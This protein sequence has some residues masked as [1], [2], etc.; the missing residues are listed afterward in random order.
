METMIVCAI[1][2]I[3]C[4][5]LCIMQVID[6]RRYKHEENLDD[7]F[8]SGYEWGRIAERENVVHVNAV[9]IEE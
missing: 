8:A 7:A 9:L 5:Y 4:I 3:V 6:L 2:G 1:T